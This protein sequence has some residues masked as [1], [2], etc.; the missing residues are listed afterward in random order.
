MLTVLT[1]CRPQML[2][3]DLIESSRTGGVEAHDCE[4][5]G[6]A[7][8]IVSSVLPQVALVTSEVG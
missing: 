2:K 4:V 6:L 1:H 8:L 7:Q 3:A 5:P